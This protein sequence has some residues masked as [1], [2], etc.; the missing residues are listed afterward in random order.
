MVESTENN[1][2]PP[3]L[4]IGGLTID[5]PTVL[6]PMAGLTDLPFRLLCARL[7][8][9]LVMT[10]VVNSQ[11]VLRASSQTMW[12]LEAGAQERPV[13]AQLYGSDPQVMAEAAA[14]IE[15]LG[16]FDLIDIN[17]GCWVSNVALRGAGAGL[18]R[19]LPRMREV[20][21][22][23]CS[24]THL[25]VTV[26]TRLGWDAKSIRIVD[27]ARMLEDIGVKALALHCRTRAQGHKGNV[28]YR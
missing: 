1:L 27:V 7:G 16:R 12:Y 22:R 8:W 19:D 26:K 9:G 6:A 2:K 5:R 25:P 17:C 23:V 11:G 18:L 14:R 28:D 3:P 24:A 10:E 15:A 13:G 21:A 4:R 20:V